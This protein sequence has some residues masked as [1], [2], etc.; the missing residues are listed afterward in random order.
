MKKT[1]KIVGVKPTLSLILVEHLTAADVNQ[2]QLIVNEN[3]DYGAPQAY[4]LD[5]GPSVP[6]GAGI[7]VGDR[8]LLQGN[9]VPVPN[10]DRNHRERGLVEM[11]NIKA[12]LHEEGADFAA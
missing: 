5:L 4:V 3:S 1:S 7:K 9:Y 10:F 6:K 8:V 2:S 11:H 12:I